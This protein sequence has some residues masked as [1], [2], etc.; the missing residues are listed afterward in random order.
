MDGD[1]RY[2]LTMWAGFAVFVMSLVWAC[3]YYAT[4]VA[5]AAIEAGM[6]QEYVGTRTIWVKK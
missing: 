6:Q 1:Q 2:W 3:T 4:S 5:K